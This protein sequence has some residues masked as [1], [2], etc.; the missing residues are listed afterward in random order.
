ML[1]YKNVQFKVS[2]HPEILCFR[3]EIYDLRE[4]SYIPHGGTD[5]F[6]SFVGWDYGHF[7]DQTI[8]NPTGREWSVEEVMNEV[9]AYIDGIH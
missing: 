3:V 7:D 4:S 5:N 8:F 2:I 9:Y 6:G 1:T